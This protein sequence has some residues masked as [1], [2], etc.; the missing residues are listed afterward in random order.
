MHNTPE[1]IK[2][3]AKFHHTHTQTHSIHTNVAAIS[4]AFHFDWFRSCAIVQFLR[5]TKNKN[6]FKLTEKYHF[7]IGNFRFFLHIIDVIIPF[8]TLFSMTKINSSDLIRFRSIRNIV[9]SH[10]NTLSNSIIFCVQFIGRSVIRNEKWTLWKWF[11]TIFFF[12]FSLSFSVVGIYRV[13]FDKMFCRLHFVVR[14]AFPLKWK[15][16]VSSYHVFAIY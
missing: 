3:A 9:L 12:A 6:F 10:K 15:T 5:D 16:I 4:F 2:C 11:S 7:I 13:A 1:L 8:V 14:F